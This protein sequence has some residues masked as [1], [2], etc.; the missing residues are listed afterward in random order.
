MAGMCFDTTSSNN[1]AC[2][3]IERVLGKD[4]LHLA[5][6]HHIM[7][8]L[9][10]AAFLASLSPSSAPEVLLLKDFSSIG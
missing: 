10:R 8:L 3:E 1:G 7:E 5:C 2:V 4:L 6:H 9:A